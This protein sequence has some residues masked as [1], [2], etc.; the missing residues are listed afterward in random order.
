MDKYYWVIGEETLKEISHD[1][2][3][4]WINTKS[5]HILIWKSGRY[6]CICHRG[7]AVWVSLR[8]METILKLYHSK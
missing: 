1:K 7:D 2:F 5:K 4:D 6:F 3:R 8:T